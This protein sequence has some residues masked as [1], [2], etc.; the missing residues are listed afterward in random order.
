MK[1]SKMCSG[2]G[3]DSPHLHHKRF[4][5]R[6]LMGDDHGF[7]RARSSRVD[8]GVGD[9]PKSSKTYRR[10]RQRLRTG[11]LSLL[12]VEARETELPWPAL[13]GPFSPINDPLVLMAN[14]NTWIMQLTR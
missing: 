10:K 3:F 6:V 9:D 11:R 12:R 1:R 4:S 13:G 7:D 14:H 8:S 2:Q 5:P